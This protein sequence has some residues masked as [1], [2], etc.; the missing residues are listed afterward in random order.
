MR[1]LASLLLVLTLLVTDAPCYSGSRVMK[2]QLEHKQSRTRA[3]AL[4][5]H[6]SFESSCMSLF[7]WLA[8]HNKRL[9]ITPRN[10]SP[11]SHCA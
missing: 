2:R 5:E 10:M 3:K 9:S 7:T 11:T 8:Q 6:Y 4:T 1:I